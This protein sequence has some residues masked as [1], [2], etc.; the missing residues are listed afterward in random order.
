[1]PTRVAPSMLATEAY[2]V[3]SNA[4]D[5]VR[6]LEVNMGIGTVPGEVARA[7]N[8]THTGYFRSGELIQD[9]I[10]EQYPYPVEL[11]KIV[12]GN[13]AKMIQ[14]STPATA[15][16]PPM[17]PRGDVI[18]NKTG[19]TN[20]FGAYVAYV[21]ATKIGIVMLAN[22]NY[23]NDARVKAAHLVLSRLAD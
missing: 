2:G 10:W 11:D 12:A 20:G 16:D 5:M 6:F 4:V 14:N 15:I 13:S 22:K 19:S 9:L 23:P 18:L 3:K 17:A 1:K 7:V 21:P 8:A